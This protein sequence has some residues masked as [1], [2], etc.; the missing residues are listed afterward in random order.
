[1]IRS[2]P[3]LADRRSKARRRPSAEMLGWSS[4]AGVFT[5]AG[6]VSRTSV[7]ASISPT[8]M[9]EWPGATTGATAKTSARAGAATRAASA[10]P[11]TSRAHQATL[12]EPP[13]R[14]NCA[15]HLSRSRAGGLRI[16]GDRDGG[17]DMRLE[18]ARR[19]HM[20]ASDR[21]AAPRDAAAGY[22]VRSR[23]ACL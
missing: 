16:S 5:L 9:S 23:S 8:S 18:G 21:R 7:L 6:R 11:R 14:V 2:V 4:S 19:A 20:G 17:P 12:S 3:A 13:P 15:T 22:K 10:M 1:M